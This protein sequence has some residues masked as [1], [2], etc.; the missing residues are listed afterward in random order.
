MQLLVGVLPQGL[1]VGRVRAGLGL[2]PRGLAEVAARAGGLVAAGGQQLGGLRL[3]GRRRAAGLQAL[4]LLRRRGLAVAPVPCLGLLVRVVGGRPGVGA[5]PLDGPAVVAAR[6]V[7]DQR[8]VLHG[9]RADGVHARL[10]HEVLA[11]LGVHLQ[12]LRLARA[13]LVE[14][15]LHGLPRERL[16]RTLELEFVIHV[17]DVHRG[18]LRHAER[19]EVHPEDAR[20]EHDVRLHLHGPVV[21]LVNALLA[22]GLPMLR[23]GIGVDVG[24]PRRLRDLPPSEDGV[25]VAL[26]HAQLLLLDVVPQ[27]ALRTLPVDHHEAEDRGAVR[28]NLL[29][30]L[31]DDRR[32]V[33]AADDLADAPALGRQALRPAAGLLVAREGLARLLVP[34]AAHVVAALR[35]GA[36]LAVPGAL[37]DRGEVRF[38]RVHDLHHVQQLWLLLRV[39][40]DRRVEHGAPLLHERR[41][42]AEQVA[43]RV[44]HREDGLRATLVLPAPSR[45]R[46]G[47][48]HL[49]LHD[50][51]LEVL[52]A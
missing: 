49:L 32:N 15:E 3:G 52:G 11:G 18:A 4:G 23:E 13:P 19:V 40:A 2:Q 47:R 39:A 9:G 41:G 20:E 51:G 21:L 7:A 22:D 33:A 6:G 46:R 16:Q 50:D 14:V 38:L 31:L 1:R 5:R 12:Q 26:V 25:R 45:A 30:R 24:R 43:P 35:A 42:L 34:S 48:A 29:G 10:H 8:E 36:V 28:R 27:G 44:A 17:R 37:R